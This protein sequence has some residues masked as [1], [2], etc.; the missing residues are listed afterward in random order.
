MK[1]I[2]SISFL[3]FFVLTLA[4]FQ[5]ASVYAQ[6]NFDVQ[7]AIASGDHKGLA[8][9][10]KSQAE[11]QRKIAGMHDAMRADYGKDHVHYKGSENVMT[12]HCMNLKLQAL[13]SADEYDALAA[14]EE[15]LAAKK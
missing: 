13:K 2:L 10:Y 1:K 7:K 4:A 9:Y 6:A 3:M 14:Q 8:E 11:A 5:S 12:G 15:K